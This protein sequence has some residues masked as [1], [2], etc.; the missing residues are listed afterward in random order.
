MTSIPA[1]GPNSISGSDP[2]D[3]SSLALPPGGGML[4][5]LPGMDSPDAITL[6][7]RSRLSQA[8]ELEEK[9]DNRY[10]RLS[11][12]VLGAAALI[13][14]PWAALTP[15]TQVVN[16][17]GEVIPEGE[18]NVMQHLEGG[19]VSRVDVS[20]GEEVR[21]GEVMLEL[22]PK[23]VGSE[24]EATEQQLKN[25]LLQQQQLQAAIRGER[26]LP[27]TD[28]IKEGNKVSK[29]Q[30][31][32]LNS[33]LDNS[34]DQI[35]ASKEIVAEKRA[36]VTGL[37]NQIAL[38]LK[39]RAMWASLVDSGAASRLNLLDIDTKL[40][41]MRGARNES[42][43]ALSQA[44]AN[45]SGVKSGLVFEQNSQIA[46]L[47][48]EEA[49]VAENIKKV[50]NQLERTK[51]VS[52]VDGVV[53]DLRFKAPG[54]VVGPGAVVLSVVPNTTQRYVEVR[55]P[56]ADIGFVKPGQKVDVKLQPFDSTIYG[57]V[58]GKVISI[59]GNSVQDPDDR[60]YYYKARIQLDRQ[61]VDVANRKYPIAV[62]MPL[63]ADI[64]GPQRSVLRYIFQP[65]TRTLD[66]AL[67]ESR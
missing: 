58:P 57:S 60:K 67:R 33:R 49:V 45:F 41:E 26:V 32:L 31:N 35:K 21:K 65:F 11:L 29:A 52:P 25:L 46:Q 19:I 22:S 50:R 2:A 39:Q 9:P 18:V 54:A 43:K 14:F 37:N 28:G 13:F 7:G 56:S 44:E 34:V 62:G 16:A 30:I 47:V 3:S 61:F 12:Y 8:L 66:S 64:K 38:Y 51:I 5:R 55:V 1:N 17:S 63:V 10:L 20:E 24:Y 53:S 23:L 6:V 4:A 15:I 36:E 40:A 42:L 59:G 48:N 27:I